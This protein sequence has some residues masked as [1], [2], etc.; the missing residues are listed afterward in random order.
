M[1]EIK[2]HDNIKTI[3]DLFKEFK[4]TDE[5]YTSTEGEVDNYFFRYVN[6]SYD[7]ND[8]NL[9]SALNVEIEGVFELCD[10]IRFTMDEYQK[11]PHYRKHIFFKLVHPSKQTTSFQKNILT[12]SLDYY[13]IKHIDDFLSMPDNV[14]I[15]TMYIVKFIEI[16]EIYDTMTYRSNIRDGNESYIQFTTLKELEEIKKRLDEV[17]IYKYFIQTENYKKLLFSTYMVMDFYDTDKSNLMITEKRFIWSHKDINVVFISETKDNEIAIGFYSLKLERKK[18][19]NI[20]SSDFL[21]EYYKP[22]FLIDDKTNHS[23]SIALFDDIPEDLIKR[24]EI[25]SIMDVL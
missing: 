19:V 16:L 14:E 17:E 9:E 25:Q 6:D 10:L 1:K 2:K 4:I 3:G 24:I 22:S 8:F 5:Y 11:F 23:G 18:L 7:S 20:T 12:L 15:E 13:H 21:R